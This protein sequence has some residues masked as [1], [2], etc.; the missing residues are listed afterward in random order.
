M[1]YP[2]DRSLISLALLDSNTRYQDEY[3]RSEVKELLGSS[4]NKMQLPFTREDFLIE[5]PIKQKG[6]SISGYQPKLSLAL[7]ADGLLNM[8][9]HQA[10]FILKPS[11]QNFPNLAANE[12]AT[13]LAMKQLGFDLPPF[14]LVRFKSELSDGEVA[15]LIRRY[16]RRLFDKEVIHQE[17]LDGAMGVAEKYGKIKNDDEGYISYEQACLFMIR[18]IDSSLAFKRE[19]FN[20]VLAAYFLGNNDLHLRNFGLLHPLGQKATL[21]PVYDYV[22]VAPYKGYI[23][24]ENSLALPLLAEEEGNNNASSG[25]HSHCT[26][27][28]YDFLNFG[29]KIGLSRKLA[30]KLITTLLKQKNKIKCI[31]QDSLMPKADVDKVL[32]WIDSRERYLQVNQHVDI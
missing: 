21:A 30:Q 5:G 14:G 4:R 9:E 16:D 15:F 27:T 10:Q 12:H 32:E 2:S 13:M 22:S 31:Y 23:A 18:N 20:R 19:L 24:N 25:Q 8:V 1:M 29:E 26:Y 3:L 17:Q 11:P 28:G 6:M 7:D